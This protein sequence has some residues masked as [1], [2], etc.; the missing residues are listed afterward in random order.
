MLP[1]MS[2]AEAA[3]RLQAGTI[4]LVDIREPDE[5]ARLS[6]PGAVLHP[7]SVADSY[8]LPPAEVPTVFTC[9]SGN[10]TRKNS[11]LLESLVSGEVWQLEGGIKAWKEQGL[12]VKENQLPLPL[13]RQIQIGAGLVILLSLLLHFVWAPFLWVTAFVGSGLIFAGLTGFC[14]LGIVLSMMPW[15]RRREGFVCCK[16]TAGKKEV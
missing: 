11:A 5:Y 4:R 8:P 9:Q 13:F 16:G 6:V 10:R 7:L 3:Q 15:N 2:P 1:V 14:G 12:S